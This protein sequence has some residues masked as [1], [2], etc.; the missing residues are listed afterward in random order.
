[1]FKSLKT[2]Q[3][4]DITDEEAQNLGKLGIVTMKVEVAEEP[5]PAGEAIPPKSKA[6]DKTKA[7]AEDLAPAQNDEVVV[8]N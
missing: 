6:K 1:M 2:K 3:L 7:A 5:A 8:A 4:L